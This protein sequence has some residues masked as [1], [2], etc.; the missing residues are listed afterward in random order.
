MRKKKEQWT[1]QRKRTTK[2]DKTAIQ[3]HTGSINSDTQNSTPRRPPPVTNGLPLA[4]CC[5]DSSSGAKYR[6]HRRP[7][8]E[9][10]TNSANNSIA[11]NAATTDDTTLSAS[12]QHPQQWLLNATASLSSHCIFFLPIYYTRTTLALPP[13]SNSDPGSQSGSS[14]P[15][16]TSARAFI[17]I[18][19]RIQLFL[20]PSSTGSHRNV[21]THAARRSQQSILFCI[22]A[23]KFK[24]SN[25][26]YRVRGVSD[27]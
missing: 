5:D 20:F 19:R 9:Y 1:A 26:L 16:P 21:P 27:F 6:R 8:T 25:R 11:R 10:K 22:F 17:F 7:H 4:H 15:F 18:A 13:S 24:I 3:Q 14:S 12:R 2:H 23:N